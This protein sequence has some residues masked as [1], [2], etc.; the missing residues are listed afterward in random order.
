MKNIF[1]TIFFSIL[2][3]CGSGSNSSAEDSFQFKNV[4]EDLTILD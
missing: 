1:L 4:P 2:M 3:S